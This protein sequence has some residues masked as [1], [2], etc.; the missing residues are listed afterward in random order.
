KKGMQGKETAGVLTLRCCHTKYC[1]GAKQDNLHARWS[2]AEPRW[3]SVHE[4]TG[5]A[6][7][8][9]LGRTT[10][11]NLFKSLAAP[12]EFGH[13]RVHRGGPHEG[14]RIFV[15]SRQEVIDRSNQIGGRDIYKG[16]GRGS[17][18]VSG[19]GFGGAD[20]RFPAHGQARRRRRQTLSQQGSERN[21]KPR[22]VK[23]FMRPL[24]SS[25]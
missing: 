15:P 16:E 4:L 11:L 10:W 3:C 19:G 24:G 1:P 12:S 18:S 23:K 8:G 2:E 17:I 20:H 7:P 6:L 5:Q 13:D 25:T 22:V 14:P 21:R 9:R